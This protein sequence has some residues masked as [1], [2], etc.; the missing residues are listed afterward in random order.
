MT[1][2]REF[3]KQGPLKIITLGHSTLRQKARELNLQEIKST[4][5]QNFIRDFV[6]TLR[7]SGYGA[8]LAANQ[9]NKLWRI[10]VV[11]LKDMPLQILVNPKITKLSGKII[12]AYEGCLS[13]PGYLGM[14]SRNDK[15]IVEA[16]NQKGEKIKVKATGFRARVLQHEIDHLNGILYIDRM[17]NMKTFMTEEE[18]GIQ[19]QEA[20]KKE[21]EEDK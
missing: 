6:Q 19:Y 1:Q 10:V 21:K 8:A 17:E 12:S 13:I 14:V 11:E 9:V 16:L 4:E 20:K 15:V 5:V 2:K 18:F 3:K 7:N